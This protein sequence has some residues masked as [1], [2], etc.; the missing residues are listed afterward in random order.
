[1]S[2]W[3]NHDDRRPSRPSHDTSVPDFATEIERRLFTVQCLG[4][5]FDTPSWGIT[6]VRVDYRAPQEHLVNALCCLNDAV[7]RDVGAVR[8][9]AERK[10]DI[11]PETTATLQ[12]WPSFGKRELKKV[13]AGDVLF[14]GYTTELLTRCHDLHDAT[15]DTVR[16]H[17]QDWIV[18]RAPKPY[19]GD[20]RFVFCV[21]L[22]RET[23]DRLHATW[24]LRSR[25]AMLR[26]Q[27]RATVRVLDA[28]PGEECRGEYKV[29]LRGEYGLVN[30][31]FA[32]SARRYALEHFL[33]RPVEGGI[34]CFG[35]GKKAATP[36][37]VKDEQEK[38]KGNDKRRGWKREKGKG[39]L[40][41]KEKSGNGQ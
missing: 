19:G 22:D 12:K 30:F 23:I 37:V 27:L 5:G 21:I 8:A 15:T 34:W 31:W 11:V 28:V 26:A 36:V 17:F 40:K 10:D 2:T 3:Y 1:M 9:Y 29:S 4:N 16:R 25:V 24:C 32:R 6:L 33:T 7:R 13:D 20:M 14:A 38:K 35:G 41:G 39:M 18:Q